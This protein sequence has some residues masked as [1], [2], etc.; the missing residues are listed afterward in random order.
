MKTRAI[1]ILFFLNG[2][3]CIVLEEHGSFLPGFVS[4]ALII[5]LLILLFAVKLNP[6]RDR[7]HLIII[8]GLLLSWAGDLTLEFSNNN[9]NMFIIGLVCF[10]LAHIMYLTVFIISPGENFIFPGR[11]YLLIP[12]VLYG[13]ALVAVLYADLGQ[14]RLPV[15]IYAAVILSMLSGAINR[16]EKVNLTSYY[17]VLAGAILFVISD[18]A[19]AVNKFSYHFS[20]SGI[21]I[22]AAYLTAQ[23]FI[24][25]GYIAQFE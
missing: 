15:I 5:P 19:I 2:I 11:S 20:S 12:V 13:F 10:L 4:K 22:M 17:M 9:G 14:M 6:F 25:K 1:T 3:L 7:L 24:V 16:K 8:A 21:V 18:S 23:Y